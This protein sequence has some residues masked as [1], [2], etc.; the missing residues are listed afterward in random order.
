MFF[1]NLHLV[2][3]TKPFELT[4]DDLTQRMSDHVFTPCGSQQ[5]TSMGWTA[6]LS[7]IDKKV[8]ASLLVHSTNNKLLICMQK[9]ERLLPASVVKEKVNIEAEKIEESQGRRVFPSEQ[10]RIRDETILTLLPKAF[11]KSKMTFA[12]I[13]VKL[14]ML[15]IDSSSAN[16]AEELMS[17]LRKSL[18]SLPVV[19][20]VLNQSPTK[21]MSHWLIHQ[22]QPPTLEFGDQCEIRDVSD[23]DVIIR[24]KG[25]DL[26][27]DE[28]LSH[29]HSGME[30]NKL[31]LQWNEKIRFL[32]KEDFQ[33]NRL[34]FNDILTDNLDDVDKD[35]LLARF[36]ADY[37]IMTSELANLVPELI[38]AFGGVDKAL[39]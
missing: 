21:V 9:E 34:K 5:L 28:F 19:P 35:D 31:E 11:T 29:L 2:R 3:F 18:G 16:H 32:L 24:S 7:V 6:P 15:I 33:V 36:D 38:Q 13:D 30:V 37:S 4:A 25:L 1:R 20:I 10:R 23:Q 12:Y 14:Q 8:D 39:G 22:S 26:S 27:S 17:L